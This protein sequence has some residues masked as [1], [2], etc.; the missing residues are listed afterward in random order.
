M[1][2]D[3]ISAR[4]ATVLLQSAIEFQ[5]AVLLFCY[6]LGQG[7]AVSLLFFME[8]SGI[9]PL[10]PEDEIVVSCWL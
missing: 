7:S 5:H 8:N 1:R 9:E 4:G 3:R 6:K 2:R 10:T